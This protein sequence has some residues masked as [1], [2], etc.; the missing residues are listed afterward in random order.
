MN[1]LC[2]HEQGMNQRINSTNLEQPLQSRAFI[3]GH[4]GQQGGKGHGYGR[5]RGEHNNFN[6]K[7][8]DGDTNSSK[9]R[10]NTSKHK[11]THI[12]C[13]KCKRYGHYKSECQMKLHNEQV[14]QLETDE[15]E[16]NLILTCNVATSNVDCQYVWYLDTRYS[17]H[18]C[19]KER[20]IFTI[21]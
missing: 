9:R 10:G 13:F 15:I 17:N 6:N 2:S 20:I 18:M 4:G 14:E 11:D 12:Q 3:G 7:N 8:G 19:G 5:S 21:K 1:S 16:Q